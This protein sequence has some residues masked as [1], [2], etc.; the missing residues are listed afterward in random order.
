MPLAPSLARLTGLLTAVTA[1][2]LAEGAPPAPAPDPLAEAR[3]L[4][5]A[6]RVPEARAPLVA[7]LA[8][9]PDNLDARI[10]LAEVLGRLHRRDEAIDL[11][12]DAV[13]KHPAD[14]NL[15]GCYGGQC[16]LRAG[17]LGTGFRALRLARRGRDAMER[18]VALKPGNLMFHEGLIDFYRQAPAIAGGDP[19]KARAHARAVAKIDPVRGAVWEAAILIDEQRYPEALAACDTALAARPDDYVAL[20][21]LGR[22]VSESGLRLAEGEAA[23]LR[24][25]ARQPGPSEPSHS[26]VHYRLGMIAEKRG[27]L[28]AARAAYRLSLAQHPTFNGPA[29]A[30]KRVE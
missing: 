22:T 2:A 27:D 12:K 26:G 29:E 24:C 16:L 18:A 11:L 10:L 9:E 28:P 19:A 25:L 3:A 1:L 23:L 13:E 17:E 14:A 4:V 21:T 8:R 20:F 30:L 5:A 7:L 15:L 6:Q